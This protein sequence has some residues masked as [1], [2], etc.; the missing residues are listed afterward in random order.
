M[1]ELATDILILC[2][3]GAALYVPLHAS[4]ATRERAIC[5]GLADG[6]DHC[7]RLA[8]T[9]AAR[10]CPEAA[11][12]LL[13]ARTTSGTNVDQRV[14]AIRVAAS[15]GHP[16]ALEALLRITAPRRRLLRMRAPPKS[17]EY[18]AALGALGHYPSDPRARAALAAAAASRDSEIAPA[19]ARPACPAAPRGTWWWLSA[20]SRPP[21]SSVAGWAC[22]W[23]CR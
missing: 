20:S 19:A 10:G 11:V 13:V 22:T 12:P 1:G 7:V 23:I 6:D 16:S 8:L 3:G 9:G 15:T 21:A 18:L 4:H 14:A 5:L 2:P 17:K